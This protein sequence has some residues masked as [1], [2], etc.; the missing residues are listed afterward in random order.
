VRVFVL[1][2][3]FV[4]VLIGYSGLLRN[5]RL[6]MPALAMAITL[7]LLLAIAL[8]RDYRERVIS[9]GVRALIALHLTR[10]V[11]IYFLW[12][13]NQGLLPRNFAVPA[14]W[15]DIVVALLAVVVLVAFRPQT[16][17]GRTAILIWNVIGLT[18]ILMVLARGAE[19]ARTDPLFQ[20]GFT[21]LPLSLLPTFI[22]PLIIVTHIVIFLW[23][24]RTRGGNT[25]SNG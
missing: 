18:D 8:R 22:V 2:W 11:G 15:G 16:P 1:S 13:Y 20:A 7:T 24:A 12:L 25:K 9:M 23:W 3:L 17:S 10:F 19:M 6:P 21:A 14:G 4:A 5:T